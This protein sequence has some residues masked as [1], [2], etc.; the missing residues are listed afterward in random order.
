MQQTSKIGRFALGLLLV[1]AL[2]ACKKNVEDVSPATP[3]YS[4]NKPVNDWIYARMQEYYFWNDKLPAYEK[5]DST[6]NPEDYFYAL[7]NEYD[8]STNPDGDR[9]SW[10]AA[11]ADSLEAALSGESVTT[12]MQF[13]L[14]L[15]KPGETAVA[16]QVLYVAKGSPAEKAGLRRGD[17]FT[18]ANGQ[19]LNTTNYQ[20]LLFTSRTATYGLA[21]V[22]GSAETITDSNV[23]RSVTPATFQEDPVYFDSVYTVGGRTVGYLVYNEFN[24]GPN[25]S[26]VATYDQ[27]I[28]RI[29]ANFKAKGVQ[30]LVLDLRYNPGGSSESAT[31][32]ASLIGKG[33]SPSSVFFK[34]QYNAG[35]TEY[36]TQEYGANSFN[37]YFTTEANAIGSQLNRVYVLTSDH[38]ASAGELLINGLKPY[39]I[40]T[41]IGEKTYGKNVGS[42]TLS[43][44][45]GK[46]KWGLQ[47]IIVKAFN[48]RGESNY[49]A[50]FT[51]DAAVEETI[52]L[53]PLGNPN[54]TLLRTAFGAISS[55]GRLAATLNRVE[56][57]LTE[58]DASLT[59]KATFGRLL[60]PNEK[61]KK[62]V[63]ARRSAE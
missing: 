16:G 33:V 37:E 36:L 62:A 61:V 13:R 63:S 44:E 42:T 59:R 30:E 58:V 34:Q 28:E 41:L 2:V 1:G 21:T 57:P 4:G 49:T 25:G 55:G 29:F 45:T 12:G 47:P 15:R 52:E 7:L 10:I 17:V 39:M 60:V 38:T 56:P 31:N 27:H 19:A 48:S 9:F 20:D 18:K 51:P 43:D 24:P 40:V 6:A 53:L 54:E 3:T 11:N 22:D 23:S 26:T 46:I 35:F 14:F 50:G 8:A 32:L 5:T